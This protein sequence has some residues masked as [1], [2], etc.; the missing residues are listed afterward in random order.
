MRLAFHPH[1]LHSG[2]T[3]VAQ[4]NMTVL[5]NQPFGNNISNLSEKPMHIQK[6]MF[7]SLF[8]DIPSHIVDLASTPYLKAN[9]PDPLRTVPHNK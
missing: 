9:D 1:L 6:I 8:V 5:P 2:F 3:L 7:V 4:E